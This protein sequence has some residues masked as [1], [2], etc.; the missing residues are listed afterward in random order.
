MVAEGISARLITGDYKPIIAALY[1]M[2]STQFFREY[3]KC[4]GGYAEC[5]EETCKTISDN[6]EFYVINQ[7][8]ET[9]GFFVKTKYNGELVLEGFH[10][11]KNFRT[12]KVFE[13]FWKIVSDTFN[14]TF[15]TGIFIGN[16]P[17]IKHLVRNGFVEIGSTESEGKVFSLLSHKIF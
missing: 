3:H 11:N 15:Y 17:A 5:V 12:P 7:G 16:Q 8:R 10:V 13:R 2:E 1:R 9:V 6:A 14:S 4:R